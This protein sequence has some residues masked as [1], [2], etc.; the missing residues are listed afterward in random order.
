MVAILDWGYYIGFSLFHIMT[1]LML[2]KKIRKIDQ[3][4]LE[5]LRS[6]FRNSYIN[7]QSPLKWT[8]KP[9]KKILLNRTRQVCDTIRISTIIIIEFYFSNSWPVFPECFYNC[10][11][12]L[13]FWTDLLRPTRL[14]KKHL[15]GQNIPVKSIT[16]KNKQ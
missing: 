3:Y 9:D 16:T 10:K 14:G 1:L 7:L 5:L 4:S 13:T 12:L 11:L 6:G 15:L 2:K 8:S